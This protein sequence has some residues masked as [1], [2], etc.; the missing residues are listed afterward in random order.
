MK[1]CVNKYGFISVDKIERSKRTFLF[2]KK[3]HDL[4]RFRAKCL[5]SEISLE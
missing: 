5:K 3:N 4:E 2:A 1:H